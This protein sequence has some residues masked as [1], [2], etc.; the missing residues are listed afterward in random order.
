ME[1]IE[2]P[3]QVNDVWFGLDRFLEDIGMTLDEFVERRMR[4]ADPSEA[5]AFVM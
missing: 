5:I 4:E 3:S 2:E 1:T